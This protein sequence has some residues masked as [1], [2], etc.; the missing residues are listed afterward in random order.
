MIRSIA[1]LVVLLLLPT[2]SHAATLFVCLM[3]NGKVTITSADPL[4]KCKGTVAIFDSDAN[5][6]AIAELKTQV[7]AL[8]AVLD[9]QPWIPDVP[10]STGNAVQD[11]IDDLRVTY[12]T[13]PTQQLAVSKELF[14]HYIEVRDVER[15]RKWAVKHLDFARQYLGGPSLSEETNMVI[16]GLQSLL[17]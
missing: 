14:L 8:Q 7:A 2:P 13:G 6:P 17:P 10:P 11:T 3:S 16:A 5:A 1:T 9:D 12:G 4:S 15:A